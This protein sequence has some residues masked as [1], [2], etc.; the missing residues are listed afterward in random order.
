MDLDVVI[1]TNSPGEL[2]SWVRVTAEKVRKKSPGARIVVMLVPCPYASGREVEI[3]S[4]FGEVDLVLSPREFLGYL[5]GQSVSK[6]VPSSRG[7]VVFLGG[8]YWHALLM[9]RKLGFPAV[10]YTDRPSSWGRYFRHV[11]VADERVKA[12]LI[13]AGVPHEKVVVVGNL[14]VEGVRPIMERATALEQWG[15]RADALTVGLFPGSRWYHVQASLSP[16]LRVAED[17]AAQATASAPVQFALGLSPFLTQQELCSSLQRQPEPYLDGQSGRLMPE[18]AGWVV[19]TE[20]GLRIPVV[21]KQQYD[22]MNLSDLVLTIP[23]TNTAEIASLGR[24]MVVAM[25]WR[26]RIPRGGLAA[27]LTWMPMQN[28]IRR[29]LL[30]GI[31]KK[32]RYTALPNQIAQREVVPEVRVEWEAGEISRVAADLLQNREWRE[33]MGTELKSLMGNGGASDRV[34][35]II[36]DSSSQS[37]P[38]HYAMAGGTA[39]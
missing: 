9:S 1:I 5:L 36:L 32:I 30:K 14:M 34:A 39:R 17:L 28:F 22:L 18:G 38:R 3:A 7:V 2:S 6:Y 26:A 4:S 10:A 15:L 11:C 12:S 29:R 23:G 33:E 35:D 20:G 13:E 8:D 37:T 25:T 27:L 21:Q 31:L 24:P 19:R 16:F